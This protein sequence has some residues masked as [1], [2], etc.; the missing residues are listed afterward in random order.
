MAGLTTLSTRS[1]WFLMGRHL[2]D[3][4]HRLLADHAERKE[5]IDA[6]GKEH[7]WRIGWREKYLLLALAD[8]IKDDPG[9]LYGADGNMAEY[10]HMPYDAFWQARRNLE[11]AGL[12]VRVG[13]SGQGSYRNRYRLFPDA[14]YREPT[15]APH[16]EVE[17][18]AT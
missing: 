6:I 18:D 1:G 13:G 2:R 16:A 4:A 15:S 7:G 5:R 17:G 10:L 12:L 8:K 3:H 9:E 14:L 11:K